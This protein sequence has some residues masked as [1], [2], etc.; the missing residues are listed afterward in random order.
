MH[1]SSPFAALS[2][3]LRPTNLSSRVIISHMHNPRISHE[4]CLVAVTHLQC[5]S[6]I[7]SQP[8]RSTFIFDPPHHQGALVSLP[9]LHLFLLQQ[10]DSCHVP[11]STH[12]KST[13]SDQP[14]D[15]RTTA[16]NKRALRSP[17]PSARRWAGHVGDVCAADA[18]DTERLVD[19]ERKD[20]QKY[21][22]W[23]L[24][25]RASYMDVEAVMKVSGWASIDDHAASG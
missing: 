14:T 20:V 9:R 19:D 25:C 4:I 7:H 17:S 18:S 21:A 22:D 10:H 2:A 8:F 24:A 1:S 12:C 15:Q 23:R 5:V 13:S 6:R 3:P 16:R 11:L